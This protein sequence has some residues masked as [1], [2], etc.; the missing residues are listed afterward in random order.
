MLATTL[1]KVSDHTYR[2]CRTAYCPVVYFSADHCHI[3]TVDH[4]REPVYQKRLDDD[5]ALVF[6]YTTGHIRGTDA[7]MVIV[8]DIS[9]GVQAGQCACDLR[10]PRGACCL[11]NVRELI[12]HS[13]PR[14]PRGYAC[15]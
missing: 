1:R 6:R 3:V 13:V 2:F 7:P 9:A 15:Q 8:D 10:N 11:G 14:G 4:I 12:R 5:A